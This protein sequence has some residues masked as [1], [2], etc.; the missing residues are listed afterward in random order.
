M[1]YSQTVQFYEENKCK[2]LTFFNDHSNEI[3]FYKYLTR[4]FDFK[5][6]LKIDSIK[7]DCHYIKNLDSIFVYNTGNSVLYLTNL[8]GNTTSRFDFSHIW[9]D[10]VIL[11]YPY[12]KTKAPLIVFKQHLILSG[13]QAGEFPGL[14]LSRKILE[15]YDSKI[16]AQS[17]EIISPQLYNRFNWGQTYYY[18]VSHTYNEKDN[19]VIISFPILHWIYVYNLLDRTTCFEE[20]GSNLIRNIRPYSKNKNIFPDSNERLKYFLEN[21]SYGSIYYDKYKQVYYRFAALPI[22]EMKTYSSDVWEKRQYSLLI[23]SRDF[24]YLGE[25]ILLNIMPETC[26]I[27]EN[28]IHIQQPSNDNELKFILFNY[29]ILAE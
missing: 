22:E 29:N 27:T 12:L 1:P 8:K 6:K 26:F 21:P 15:Y 3:Y 24:K 19:L 23:Y 17:F 20:F 14:N 13:Y 10:S 5:W 4:E 16:N 2:W 25:T 7:Y 28:G 11:P 9:P 18:N